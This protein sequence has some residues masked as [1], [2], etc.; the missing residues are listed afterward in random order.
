M[1]SELNASETKATQFPITP[2]TKRDQ[3]VGCVKDLRTI[4]AE[5]R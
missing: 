5:R 4:D 1:Y 2:F 3:K